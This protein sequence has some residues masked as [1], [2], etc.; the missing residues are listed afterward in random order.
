VTGYS[1]TCLINITFNLCQC[2]AEDT[3]GSASE[4]QTLSGEISSNESAEY[5]GITIDNKFSNFEN[6]CQSGLS[7]LGLKHSHDVNL[8]GTWKEVEPF[9]VCQ[10]QFLLLFRTII[11]I[12]LIDSIFTLSRILFYFKQ[13]LPVAYLWFLLLLLNFNAI[14]K[15]CLQSVLS[16]I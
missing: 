8:Q 12:V 1:S 3:F 2:V 16:G 4:T 13:F 10:F 7:H 11:M 6:F 14:L 9:S 15:Y 5:E